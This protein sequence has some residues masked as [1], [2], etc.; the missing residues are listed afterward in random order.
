MALSAIIDLSVLHYPKNKHRMNALLVG[1]GAWRKE[2]P[3]LDDTGNKID[4]FKMRLCRE[5]LIRVYLQCKKMDS[6][7]MQFRERCHRLSLSA[8]VEPYQAAAAWQSLKI[9]LFLNFE[10]STMWVDPHPQRAIWGE[11][12][13]YTALQKVW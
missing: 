13:I 3:V 10:Q 11:S 2:L 8:G 7:A 5:D 9:W 12:S 6:G 4:G 1:G